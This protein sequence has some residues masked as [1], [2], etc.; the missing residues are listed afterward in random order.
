MADQSPAPAPLPVTKPM[1]EP[2][3]VQKFVATFVLAAFL[4]VILLMSWHTVP[5]ENKDML[6][7]LIGFIGG[8]FTA[9][10]AFYFGSTSSSHTKD[11]TIAA[12]TAVPPAAPLF[13][14]RQSP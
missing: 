3:N 1:R 6:E 14:E 2:Q 8:A 9:V 4:G 7:T 13:P 12:M 10:V 11:Q 5:A